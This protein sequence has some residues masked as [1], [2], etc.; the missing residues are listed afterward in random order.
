MGTTAVPGVYVAGNV[1]NIAAQVI[2]AAA[3]GTSA[4]MMI[5]A[6]LI[7]E[8]TAWAVE[9]WL[10][11]FSSRIEAKVSEQVLGS[12]RH[13]LDAPAAGAPAPVKTQGVAAG[14]VHR[15]G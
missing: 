1:S 9:G 4:G 11:P 15:A 3:E 5:N 14:G 12:R 8:E 7:E 13:G 6:H 2:V 10:G